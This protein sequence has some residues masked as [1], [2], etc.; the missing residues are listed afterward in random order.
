MGDGKVDQVERLV[1]LVGFDPVKRPT[2]TDELMRKVLGEMQEERTKIAEGHVKEQLKL[3]VQARED[4]H[5]LKK[6]FDGQHR[7]FE[8]NLG[9]I[10]N[11]LE[12]SLRS[13]QAPAEPTSEAPATGEQ[14]QS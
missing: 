4:M 6:E 8:E 11:G 9:K 2:P 5:K 10:L 14:T 13:S 1:K 7:K 12:S 3:A